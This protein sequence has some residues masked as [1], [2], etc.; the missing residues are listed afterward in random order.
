VLLNLGK[1]SVCFSRDYIFFCYLT[2]V[3]KLMSVT[4]ELSHA[5]T[6]KIGPMIIFLPKCV[7]VDSNLGALCTIPD[8]LDNYQ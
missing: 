6:L 3:S 4:H 8:K 7:F 2:G 5:T 1:N